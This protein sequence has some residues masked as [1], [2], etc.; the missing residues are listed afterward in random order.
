MAAWTLSPREMLRSSTFYVVQQGLQRSAR[1]VINAGSQPSLA[2]ILLLRSKGV[3]PDDV[4]R[5]RICTL[6]KAA[7]QFTREGFFR[8]SRGTVPCEVLPINMGQGDSVIWTKATAD[9]LAGVKS[10][11]SKEEEEGLGLDDYPG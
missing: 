10:G 3:A 11:V 2:S 9:E 7:N 5:T 1:S 4:L 6:E 8:L